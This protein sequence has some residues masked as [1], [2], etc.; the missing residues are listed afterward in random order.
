MLTFRLEVIRWNV[1]GPS[2]D[3]AAIIA[4][5]VHTGLDAK[6]AEVSFQRSRDVRFSTGCGHG[7]QHGKHRSGVT[8]TFCYA[9]WKEIRKRRLRARPRS[10]ESLG[11]TGKT[12][13]DDQDETG[14]P[15]SA[16]LGDV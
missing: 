6:P 7:H 1:L 10:D 13:R 16:G 14:V 8:G 4:Q 9:S 15:E 11:L 12:D 3:F 2:E 5:R